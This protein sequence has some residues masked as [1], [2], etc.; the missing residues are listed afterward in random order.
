MTDDMVKHIV[1]GAVES[2][3]KR[4][5]FNLIVITWAKLFKIVHL[6]LR[7]ALWHGSFQFDFAVKILLWNG[8]SYVMEMS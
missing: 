7:S 3:S 2:S 6:L 5:K 4:E 1:R 8:W